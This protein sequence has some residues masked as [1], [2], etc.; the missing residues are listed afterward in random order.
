[1][2]PAAPPLLIFDSFLNS[3]AAAAAEDMAKSHRPPKFG[4][5]LSVAWW[6]QKPWFPGWRRSLPPEY[7]AMLL[8]ALRQL[9]HHPSL[10]ERIASVHPASSSMFTITCTPPAA[11]PLFS[12]APHHDEHRTVALVHYLSSSWRGDPSG[13]T[14]FYRERH[15][16]QS[17]F[18]PADCAAMVA[19][20]SD[21]GEVSAFCVGSLADV[22]FRLLTGEAVGLSLIERLVASGTLPRAPIEGQRRF[23]AERATGVLSM[24]RQEDEP[25][26]Y[27]AESDDKFELIHAVPYR[28]N[29]LVVYDGSLLHAVH[30]DRGASE[31]LSCN[32]DEGRLTASIFLEHKA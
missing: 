30:L 7:I 23:C 6:E 15:S 8:P 16:G 32:V 21:P 5:P 13:G 24:M 31:A 11:L 18:S 20:A 12:R 29:R 25:A 4:S 10:R 26:K 1:M 19:N 27:M 9:S 14:G 3:S 22:C 17:R 2:H 28:Y